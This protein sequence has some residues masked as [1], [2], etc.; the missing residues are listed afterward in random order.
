MAGIAAAVLVGFGAV[1]S[2]AAHPSP[3]QQV[4]PADAPAGFQMLLH[5]DFAVAVPADWTELRTHGAVEA[6]S[7]YGAVEATIQPDADL[8]ALTQAWVDTLTTASPDA[9]IIRR[10]AGDLVIV[11][12]HSVGVIDRVV[13]VAIDGGVAQVRIGGTVDADAVLATIAR[14]VQP[15]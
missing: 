15:V 7:P 1:E 12:R 6:G 11:E 8:A 4:S 9:R 5:D 3:S 14:S 13:L 10:S 2:P